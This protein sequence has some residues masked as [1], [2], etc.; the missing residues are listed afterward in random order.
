METVT[1][2]LNGD[3]ETHGTVLG[4]GPAWQAIGE[5][6]ADGDATRIRIN[7]QD[8]TEASSVDGTPLPLTGVQVQAVRIEWEA[9]GT[10]G[11]GTSA[12]VG[13]RIGGVDYW[14]PAVTLDPHLYGGNPV[15]WT[16]NPA[17]GAPWSPQAARAVVPLFQTTFQDADFGWPRLTQRIV[18]VD[19]VRV[20]ERQDAS[21]SGNAPEADASGGGQVAS[22][23]GGPKAAASG[24]AVDALA[25][26]IASPAAV[27][28]PTGQAAS[29]SVVAPRARTTSIVGCTA[30]PSSN[31]PGAAVASNAPAASGEATTAQQSEGV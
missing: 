16:V 30:S 7:G 2:P 29:G 13:L 10:V 18:K 23:T 27:G 5:D 4:G 1:L 3:V 28:L 20:P 25:R 26:A 8:Q 9:A 31:S 19:F 21:G 14:A 17:T 15:E 6:P 12:R 22:G 24:G 11:E